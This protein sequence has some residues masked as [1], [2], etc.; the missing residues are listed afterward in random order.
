MTSHLSKLSA[1][2]VSALL[3]FAL[4][5][6]YASE[7]PSHVDRT[8]VERSST[9]DTPTS[10]SDANRVGSA[11]EEAD[12]PA[13]EA[14]SETASNEENTTGESMTED[15]AS[16]NQNP[17]P[18]PG[19]NSNSGSYPNENPDF[20]TASEAEPQSETVSSPIEPGTYLLKSVISSSRVVDISDAS[21]SDGANVQLW[22]Y[23]QTAAQLFE[24]V[25]DENGWY[26]IRN[27]CSKKVLDVAWG[28]A[29]AGANVH[30]YAPND[31]PAQK[32]NAI[33][34]ADGTFT[35]E[36][37]LAKGLVLDVSRASNSDG[38]NMQIWTANRTSAQKFKLIE[39]YPKVEPG[40]VIEP[41]V[42]RL[43][44]ALPDGRCLDISSAGLHN[45]C[46]SQLWTDN[47]TQAQLFKVEKAT[48]GFYFLKAVHSGKALD[49]ASGWLLPG[50][51][52]QQ[53]DV[54]GNANQ[55]WAFRQNEDGTYA[56]VC[57]ASGLALDVSGACDANGTPV[58]TYTPNGTFA[59]KWFL[60]KVD[61]LLSDGVYDI[62]TYIGSRRV[63]DIS[64]CSPKEN[65]NAQTWSWNG[66]PAQRFLL[67]RVQG[68]D[69][70]SYTIEALCS[71]MLLTQKNSNVVQALAASGADAA[72]QQWRVIPAVSGGLSF[73]NVATGKYLDVSSAG[74]WDGC[75][76]GV[77]DSNGTIA[78]SFAVEKTDAVG[79]GTY[80]I[81]GVSD[82][83]A[84]DVSGGSRAN[85]ANVQVWS[86][87]D[88][89][90]QK[91]NV[92]VL[93]GGW[94]VIENAQSGKALDVLNYGT[95][96]GTNVQ[97][98]DSSGNNA[99]KWSIEYVGGG[100][101]SFTSAC[102][103]LTLDVADSGGYDGA[104]VQVYTPN[105]SAAQKFTLE[106]A[107]Y[108][109]VEQY[110]GIRW[111]GQPNGYY[112][113]PTSGYMILDYLGAARSTSGTPLTIGNVAS[114]MGANQSGISMDTRDFQR[115]MNN[116][117]G[118]NAYTTIEHPSYE[119]VRN[120]ILSSFETG[121][122]V[123]VHTWE[124]R[125]GPHYN[126]HANS[127]M[128]HLMVVD[129]YNSETD[130]VYIADPWAGVWSNSSQK[131]W[132]GS[133]REFASTYIT[134]MRGIYTH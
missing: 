89:G 98:W 90:A 117:L 111:T 40:D 52:V 35:F 134:P 119:T 125:G 36:S 48:E 4:T 22:S 49:S 71:G 39:A 41:G 73:I 107:A 15:F 11:T 116:W 9:D 66:S 86:I 1:V 104:N 78:Q 124:R 75:N 112:C 58:V 64:S 72:Y 103:N 105:G 109:P 62:K 110:L 47:G 38:A 27:V 50:A 130:A 133:L 108:T 37:A 60:E 16:P 10:A 99:Q 5:P 12:D 118:Y 17:D 29:S 8:R 114:Y 28:Q 55:R 95:K 129:G 126:G 115:G 6:A 77:W 7:N 3:C 51:K 2:A 25:V 113:G 56:L 30:Q 101:Y 54:C 132:Y 43:R 74:D 69:F 94:Y 57:S 83:R 18:L 70:E 68:T 106:Q 102:G 13:E 45:A 96:P 44:S 21:K 26:T 84:L 76:V 121:Y 91:W 97:Q 65:A 34:N 87:N 46:P 33:E 14:A 19:S 120:A 61:N 127:T 81:R 31:T 92:R 53:W 23:N 88:T 59:Q 82:R 131:F 93:D 100:A 63:L 67:N 42:Y 128:G 123:S 20:D 122:P 32:W 85:G 79:D 80:V 24:L